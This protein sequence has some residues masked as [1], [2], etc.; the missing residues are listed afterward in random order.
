MDEVVAAIFESARRNE[1][2][3]PRKHHLVPASY[4]RRWAIDDRIRVTETDSHHTYTTSPEKAA[5]ETDFY[6]LASEE[7]DNHNIP[8]LLFETLLSKI[9]GAAMTCIDLLLEG[10]PRALSE[11]DA[12]AFASFL[13]F[14]ITRGR[15]FRARIMQMANAGLLL[16]WEHITDAGIAQKLREQRNEEPSEEDVVAIRSFLE[17]WRAGKWRAG[18]QQA[19]LV[20]YAAMMA[21]PMTMY[22]LGRPWRIYESMMPLITCDEPVVPIQRPLGNPR[23]EPGIAMAGTIVVPLDAYHLLAMFHPGLRLDEIALYPELLPTEADELNLFIAAHSDRWMFERPNRTRT[24]TLFVPPLPD[25]RV[26]I[27]QIA[28]RTDP[29]SGSIEELHRLHSPT[30][31][32]RAWRVPKPPVER[33]WRYA[34]VP[35]G[36]DHPYDWKTMDFAL[37]N[38]VG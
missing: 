24:A 15:A 25:D 5:R 38:A 10:G 12:L 35:G 36:Q 7:L 27:S 34:Q 16:M 2:S 21:E 31:W 9:E 13:A 37:C 3:A 17:E 19:A 33:W 28:Q 11:M 26:A 6:S 8:P 23:E 32:S 22:F 20:G 14:Q 29:T 30:R 1:K 4:L 18:S